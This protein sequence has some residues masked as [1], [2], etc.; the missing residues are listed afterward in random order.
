MAKCCDNPLKIKRH[1]RS[2]YAYEQTSLI[3]Q[4]FCE[5]Y[6][7]VCNNLTEGM[8]VC[9]K[10]REKIISSKSADS[11][12]LC[13]DPFSQGPHSLT[14]YLTVSKNTQREFFSFRH[15]LPI[16]AKLCENCFV[17]LNMV[18]NQ[19]RKPS[20]AQINEMCCNPFNLKDHSA[21][22]FGRQI[23]Q[24][25]ANRYFSN[26]IKIYVGDEIC[27]SCRNLLY[28]TSKSHYTENVFD[29]DDDMT[30]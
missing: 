30:G 28:T 2:A 23:T 4:V 16:G 15:R 13:V 22:K 14:K 6:L 7:T 5:T 27:G 19:T 25:I 18:P 8:T 3:D 24:T 11:K 20:V 21:G 26:D 1:Y 10:C 9:S 12:C 29:D 17:Q